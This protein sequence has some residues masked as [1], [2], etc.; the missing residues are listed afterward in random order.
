MTGVCH[1]CVGLTRSKKAGRMKARRFFGLVPVLALLVVTSSGV[2]CALVPAPTSE[3]AWH[4]PVYPDLMPV[5]GSALYNLDGVCL[6]FAVPNVTLRSASGNREN[7]VLDDNN[8]TTTSV[9]VS[10]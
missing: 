5:G 6:R 9:Y 8:N 7:V 3:A 1:V 2:G 4:T 10:I